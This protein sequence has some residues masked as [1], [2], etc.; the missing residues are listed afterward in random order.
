MKRPPI[1]VFESSRRI[2][3]NRD[4]LE[5]ATRSDVRGAREH[6]KWNYVCPLSVSLK[7]VP[8]VMFDSFRSIER[9]KPVSL[10]RP[11]VVVFENSRSIERLA[12]V[13]LKRPPV[14]VFDRSRSIAS[15][16]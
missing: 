11:S 9:L 14:I 1:A 3:I 5:D 8:V 2:E 15:G 13:S 6:R 7:S 16:S 4:V 10:K 12:P